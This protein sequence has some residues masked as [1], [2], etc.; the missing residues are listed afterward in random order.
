[1]TKLF[2]PAIVIRH[3]PDGE[4]LFFGTSE[5][6]QQEDVNQIIERL[7]KTSNNFSVRGV[8]EDLNELMIRWAKWEE[9]H[10]KIVE[11]YEDMIRDGKQG[12]EIDI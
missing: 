5:I 11:E 3:E 12:E 4:L 7:L 8:H 1:M 2:F 9:R 6:F 10:Y